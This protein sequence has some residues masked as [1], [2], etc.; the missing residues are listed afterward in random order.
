MLVDTDI[1]IWYLRGYDSARE[2]LAAQR[3]ISL[4]AVTYMELVQGMRN[5][6]ELQTLRSELREWGVPILPVT[7][8]IS[9]RAAFYVE[10]HFLSHSLRLADVLIA[11]TAVEIGAPLATG[12]DRHYRVIAELKIV[13][14]QP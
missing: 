13:R 6:A 1:F 7:E 14:Y 8:A 2:F 12:N 11:A 9:H 3:K 4:S 10:Q 5:Q